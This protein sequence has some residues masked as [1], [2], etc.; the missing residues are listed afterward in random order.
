MNRIIVAI[1]LLFI[2]TSCKKESAEESREGIF[3]DKIYG[4]EDYGTYRDTLAIISVNYDALKR[5]VSMTSD[6]SDNWQYFYNGNEMNPNRAIIESYGRGP[7]TVYFTYNSN[8]LKTK[9]SILD[10]TTS[11]LSTRVTNYTYGPN[12]V[13]GYSYEVGGTTY[14]RDTALLDASGNII[15]SR[16]RAFFDAPTPTEIVYIKSVFTYDSRPHP[17]SSMNIFNSN[18]NFPNGETFFLEMFTPNNIVTQREISTSGSD[19]D[20]ASSYEYFSNGYPKRIIY[21]DGGGVS[22]ITEFTYRSL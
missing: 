7:Y 14:V 10:P 15:E 3:I 4:I 17:F 9:D 12:S 22:E 2:F 11:P 13:I 18:R 19:F 6:I 8:G 1:S 20:I 16:K 21:N 5:V